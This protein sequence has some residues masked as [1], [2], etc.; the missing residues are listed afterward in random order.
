[1]MKLPLSH[2]FSVSDFIIEKPE[3]D[4]KFVITLNFGFENFGAFF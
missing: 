4:I 3:I 1:M 2:Y